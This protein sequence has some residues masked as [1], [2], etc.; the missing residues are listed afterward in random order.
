MYVSLQKF[1]FTGKKER[2]SKEEE[3]QRVLTTL[4]LAVLLTNSTNP[5]APLIL[6]SLTK[7]NDHLYQRIHP[8]NN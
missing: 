3:K 5:Y 8:Q 4:R 6:C 7:R 2:R 1:N